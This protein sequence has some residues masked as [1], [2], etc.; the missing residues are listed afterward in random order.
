M[1]GTDLWVTQPHWSRT[2]EDIRDHSS[3][4]LILARGLILEK[5]PVCEGGRQRE[6]VPN[7]FFL[8]I[9]GI[10]RGK[11][12]SQTIFIGTPLIQ[13]WRVVLVSSSFQVGVQKFCWRVPSFMKCTCTSAAAAIAPLSLVW[14][15]LV[16]AR[17]LVLIWLTLG[18][19]NLSVP[20]DSSRLCVSRA[21]QFLGKISQPPIS[22]H[23]SP[24]FTLLSAGKCFSIQTCR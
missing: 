16:C 14:V 18:V 21:H 8:H 11:C 6:T 9:K 24:L 10:K 4:K 7:C 1:L 3:S 17:S 23:T 20:G 2:L 12:S 5:K 19:L 13:A 15:M 22:A